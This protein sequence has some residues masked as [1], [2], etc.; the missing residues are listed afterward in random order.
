MKHAYTT[1]EN[2]DCM[3]YYMLNNTLV[4]TGIGH[5]RD[6]KGTTSLKSDVPLQYFNWD[7]FDFMKPPLNKVCIKCELLL[8]LLHRLLMD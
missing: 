2:T 4:S 1:M 8:L 6:I 5:L 3:L 7:E